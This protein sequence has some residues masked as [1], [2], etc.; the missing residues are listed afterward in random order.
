M[1]K[2]IQKS[3]DADCD[4]PYWVSLFFDWI[5]ASLKEMHFE[6]LCNHTAREKEKM[7]R[8][9]LW[10][11]ID[12]WMQKSE[13]I[14]LCSS[15]EKLTFSSANIVVIECDERP[16][17]ARLQWSVSLMKPHQKYRLQLFVRQ[18][19][20]KTKSNYWNGRSKRHTNVHKIQMNTQIILFIGMSNT[21]TYS[22]CS[23]NQQDIMS[24]GLQF[25]F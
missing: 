9:F 4:K 17:C 2:N 24:F 16:K 11:K 22:C 14:C 19:I 20:N 8:F 6:Y 23:W 10:Q 13:G 1:Q 15:D 25:Q 5:N 3:R 18:I 7:K 12:G 21:L